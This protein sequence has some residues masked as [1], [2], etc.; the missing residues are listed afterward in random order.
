MMHEYLMCTVKHALLNFCQARNFELGV[1]L[2]CAW[3]S[4]PIAARGLLFDSVP[5]VSSF[6][7]SGHVSRRSQRPTSQLLRLQ[8]TAHHHTAVFQGPGVDVTHTFLSGQPV[9]MPFV[10]ASL[11]RLSE[12]QVPICD[13]PAKSWSACSGRKEREGVHHGG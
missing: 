6:S 5:S 9:Y 1:K 10:S 11:I 8:C 4:Q 3:R 12:V 13:K 7:D 2:V